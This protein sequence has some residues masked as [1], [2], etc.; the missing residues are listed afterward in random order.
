MYQEEHNEIKSKI[1]S[2]KKELE[3]TESQIN[4]SKSKDTPKSIIEAASTMMASLNAELR[5]TKKELETVKRNLKS[6]RK[7]RKKSKQISH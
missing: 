2:A 3:I 6:E 1:G 5:S 7:A 4:S